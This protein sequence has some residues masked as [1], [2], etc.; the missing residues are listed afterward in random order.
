[1]R[2]KQDTGQKT[3]NTGS[4]LCPVSAASDCMNKNLILLISINKWG[5]SASRHRGKVVVYIYNKHLQ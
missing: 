3:I 1:M 4:L 5:I 2:Q